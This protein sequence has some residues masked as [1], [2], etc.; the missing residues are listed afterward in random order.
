MR[1]VRRQA[2]SLG[3]D[4]SHFTGQRRWTDEELASAVR[5]AGSWHD[6]V[7]G[8]GLAG[9]SSQATLKGH[10]KRLGLD[11]EH[12]RPAGEAREVRD[13]P[14]VDLDNL[15][16]A[17]SM[18]AAAWFTL[19]GYEVSWPLEPCRYD[20]LACKGARVERVQVKTTTVRAG[21]SW[22]AWISTT[23]KR[24]VAYDPDEI[25]C[26]FVIDGDLSMYRIPVAVVG[27]FHAISLAA[28]RQYQVHDG[29]RPHRPA[30]HV[31]RP[32]PAA[33]SSASTAP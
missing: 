2:D 33:R 27:G 19:C 5:A 28:Y 23:G 31:P 21:A 11:V 13:A 29:R 17:G 18:M 32:R 8:L 7:V 22:T 10:A 24:R 12:L 16:R 4:Y 6:V 26:F 3:L 25:D 1:S 14:T 20:L 9:V 30:A 15:S